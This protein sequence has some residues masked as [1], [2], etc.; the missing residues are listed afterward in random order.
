VTDAGLLDQGEV[1]SRIFA[2][3]PRD[4]ILDLLS[5]FKRAEA[6]LLYSADVDEHVVASIAGLDESV[7]F[8]G[9]EPFDSPGSH[10]G[11]L[12]ITPELSPELVLLLVL[13]PVIYSSA[14]GSS[15]Y[16]GNRAF[17]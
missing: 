11:L 1:D 12:L 6:S 17:T 15:I 9:I 4:F 8:L 2:A 3:V 10:D 5:F 14:S 13:P 7:T 16:D